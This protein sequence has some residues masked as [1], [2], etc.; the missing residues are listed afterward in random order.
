MHRLRVRPLIQFLA[1]SDVRGLFGWREIDSDQILVNLSQLSLIRV[2]VV[3]DGAVDFLPFEFLGRFEAMQTN[4][5]P[6]ATA[7]VPADDYGLE[8]ALDSHGLDEGVDGLF[9]KRP[10]ATFR[11]RDAAEGDRSGLG[12]GPFCGAGRDCGF[13][14]VSAGHG[15]PPSSSLAGGLCLAPVT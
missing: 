9:P 5:K 7:I 10:Q 11:D 13:D 2:H 1:L 15:A 4:H 12:H 8:L 14:L 3:E 6:V